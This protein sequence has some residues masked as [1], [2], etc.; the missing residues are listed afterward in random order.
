M[1]RA[2]HI[3]LHAP[4][5][6]ECGGKDFQILMCPDF[7]DAKLAHSMP[8]VVECADCDLQHSTIPF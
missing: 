8:Y 6:C 7:V 4:D 2:A 1:D 3:L 5:Q